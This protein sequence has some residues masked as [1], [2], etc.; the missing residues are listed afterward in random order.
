MVVRALKRSESINQNIWFDKGF[1]STSY[2]NTIPTPQ[3]AQINTWGK[4]LAKWD[5]KYLDTFKR[6]QNSDESLLAELTGQRVQAASDAQASID[7]IALVGDLIA[8]D[9]ARRLMLWFC[10]A[11]ECAEL[12]QYITEAFYVWLMWRARLPEREHLQSRLYESTRGLLATGA[13]ILAD[14]GER[15]W[16]VIPPYRGVD[17]RE[18]V[19]LLWR[20]PLYRFLGSEAPTRRNHVGGDWWNEEPVNCHSDLAWLYRAMLC[21][22]GGT[23]RSGQRVVL[24]NEILEVAWL[25]EV[26]TV[27]KDNGDS[28]ILPLAESYEAGKIT[29]V[30]T[31]VD[32]CFD[33]VRSER[34][35]V[36]SSS[37]P[38]HRNT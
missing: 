38:G 7:D 31:S 30:D 25:E 26:M 21:I 22:G 9:E 19:W 12:W 1:V 3:V 17:F 8:P 2:H 33:M 20:E 14:G 37:L 5:L 28:L 27:R 11:K 16:P 24:P 13:A 15:A 10:R 34:K 32:I 18:F 29:S 36:V 23:D 6:L 35:I 4:N